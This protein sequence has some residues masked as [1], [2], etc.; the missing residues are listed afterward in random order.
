MRRGDREDVLENATSKSDGVRGLP[1]KRERSLTHDIF[2]MQKGR[3]RRQGRVH[4]A[5]R[6]PPPAHLPPCPEDVT[7]PHRWTVR[8]H[9]RA[10]SGSEYAT[11][12]REFVSFDRATEFGYLLNVL[13]KPSTLQCGCV[14]AGRHLIGVS[15]FREGVLPEWEDDANANGYDLCLRDHG[16]TNMDGAWRNAFAS[17]SGGILPCVG[18]RV[19]VRSNGSHRPHK[20]LEVWFPSDV[21]KSDADLFVQSLVHEGVWKVTVHSSD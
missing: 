2:L 20:K 18:I 14:C 3:N 5:L 7:L 15:V 11:S 1:Y 6:A 4:P 19:V 8:T 9:S 12:H 21:P 13:P 10:A 17:M 16:K